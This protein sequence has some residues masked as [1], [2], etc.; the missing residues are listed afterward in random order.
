MKIKQVEVQ[1][2]L[3]GSPTVPV[4]MFTVPV[5]DHDVTFVIAKRCEKALPVEYAA[6]VVKWTTDLENG[7]RLAHKNYKKVRDYRLGVN[8]I[9]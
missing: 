9:Q 5:N 8:E 7:L 2:K 6:S 1:N 4:H 3:A